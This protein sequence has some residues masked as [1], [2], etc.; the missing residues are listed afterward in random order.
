[1]DIIELHWKIGFRNV[2]TK[3]SQEYSSSGSSLR[4]FNK[5]WKK[6]IE[7]IFIEWKKNF[8]I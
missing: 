8:E 7:S 4:P 2:Y 5:S 6:Q 1:M 3:K